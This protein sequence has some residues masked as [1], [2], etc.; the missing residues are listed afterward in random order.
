VEFIGYKVA[1]ING[2]DTNIKITT[3]IDIEL[4]KVLVKKDN[5]I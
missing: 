3:P 1:T 4:A 2:E 5:N